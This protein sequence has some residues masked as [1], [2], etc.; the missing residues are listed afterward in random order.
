[1]RAGS[2]SN[3]AGKTALASAAIWALAGSLSGWLGDS[4]RLGLARGDVVNHSAAVKRARVRLRGAVGGRPFA[5]ERTATTSKGPPLRPG[6][7]LPSCAD[8]SLLRVCCGTR[9]E[10]I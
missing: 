8:L 10:Y 9:Q 4:G 3:G 7:A 5:I 1:M 6:T 2:L